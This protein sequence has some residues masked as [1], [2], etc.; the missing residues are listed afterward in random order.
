[1][2]RR[3]ERSRTKG[4]SRAKET[5]RSSGVAFRM[6]TLEESARRPKARAA[7]AVPDLQRGLH[8]QRRA[9]AVS[10]RPLVGGH[11]PAR[12]LHQVLPDDAEVAALLAL[13]LLTDARRLARTSANGRARPVG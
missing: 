11:S 13:M 8:E 7:Y 1:M 2:V 9:D 10:H 12:A 3:R 6:P 5:S 4:I